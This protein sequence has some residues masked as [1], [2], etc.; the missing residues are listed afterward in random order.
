MTRRKRSTATADKTV[1]CKVPPWMELSTGP[2]EPAS[3]VLPRGDQLVDHGELAAGGYASVHRALDRNLLRTV[4]MKVLHPQHLARPTARLRFLEEAQITGQLDHPNIVPVHEMGVDSEGRHF[5][6]MKLVEGETLTAMLDRV[7]L[8]HAPRTELQ[9]LL[10]IVVRVCDALAFAHSRGVIHRDLKP[11]NIMV[12]SHGQVYVMDWGIALLR[13]GERPSE[14][15][16]PKV[17]IRRG[18]VDAPGTVIG[19]PAYMAPEQARGEVDAMDHQT[20]IYMVGA[21]LYTILTGGPPHQGSG[22]TQKISRAATGV[23]EAPQERAGRRALPARLCDITMRCLEPRKQD[24]YPS[25]DAL[26]ADL[27]EFLRAGW[28]F[29]QRRFPKGTAII[30]EGDE[31]DAAYIITSGTCEVFHRRGGRKAVLRTLG[32]GHVFGETA[33]FSERP[34]TASVRAVTTVTCMVVTRQSLEEELGADSWMG[35]FVRALSDRFADLDA[36]M[37]PVPKGPRR[38]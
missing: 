11:D 33:I 28:W 12:G 36:R 13:G 7:D 27:E 10:H 2:G 16:D 21:I 6:T 29:S 15:G 5:F 19:T 31:A 8:A 25:V 1:T 35:A 17:R 26:K 24:R 14:Q 38:G 18:R 22:V 23:V 32:P 9:K 4:A 37:S 30:R 20:D 34:R 3:A